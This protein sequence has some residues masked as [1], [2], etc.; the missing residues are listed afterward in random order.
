MQST[1]ERTARP[2]DPL[3]SA[4]YAHPAP[5]TAQRLIG[6]LLYREMEDGQ[7]VSGRI[8]ETEAY[9]QDDPACHAYNRRTPRCEVLYGAAGHAYVYFTYGIHHCLNV[10]CGI[11]G[12]AEGVLIRAIEPLSGLETMAN[13]RGINALEIEAVRQKRLLCSGPGKICQALKIDGSFNGH[14]LTTGSSLWIGNRLDENVRISTGVRVG[15]SKAKEREW[16]FMLQGSPFIS[17]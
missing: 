7:I 3:P 5:I 6:C 10:V 4:F 1:H 14:D 9:T 2:S 17:K 12:W 15:I 8:V 11:E 16:R 13:N